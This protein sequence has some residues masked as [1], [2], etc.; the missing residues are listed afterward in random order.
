MSIRS[1]KFLT[2]A[3][4]DYAGMSIEDLRALFHE[5]LAEGMHGLCFSPYQEGQ[6]PGDQLSEEQIRRRL[7]IIKPYT[8][9]IRSFSCTEGNEQI[10]RIAKMSG[11][12]TMIGAWIGSDKEQNNVEI[13]NLIQLAKEGVVDIAVVGNEVLLRNDLSE[14]EILTYINRVKEAIPGIPVGYVDAYYQFVERPAL[15]EACDTLLVNCYPFWEG[16]SIEQASLYL[17]QMYAVT[18]GIAQGKS[19]IITET[20]WPNKGESVKDAAPSETNAMKYFLNVNAWSQSRGIPMFYFSS[21]DE[22]W[23]VHHEGDVGARWGLWNKNEN[24]KY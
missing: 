17:K 20:G 6:Q 22:S 21:F 7:E 10:A 16:S 1:E 18:K 12:K 5:Y 8:S 24:L 19:V 13:E 23:K 15:V 11:L 14:N 2:L 9:W 4:V 3:S